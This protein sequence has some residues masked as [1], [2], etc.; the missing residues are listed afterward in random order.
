[1]GTPTNIEDQLARDE[2]RVNHPYKDTVGKWTIGIGHLLG[3]A[4]PPQFA[5]GITDA[6]CDALFSADLHHVWDLLD[7]YVPWWSSLDGNSGPRS[8]VLV[9]MG[10]NLGVKGLASFHGF[11]NLMRDK[12]W[13]GAAADLAT[14]AVFKQLPVR[15][16]RLQQQIRTGNWV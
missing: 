14:T 9:N 8:N 12:N 4:I 10:F 13:E 7:V 5:N 6:T 1:M 3:D 15:Y 2:G 11:L 16:G